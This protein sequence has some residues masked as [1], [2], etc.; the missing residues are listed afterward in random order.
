L[1]WLVGDAFYG[2]TRGQHKT[3]F[4]PCLIDAVEAGEVGLL[5]PWAK[6][7]WRKLNTWPFAWGL[8]FSVNC[9]DDA[10]GYTAASLAA[11]SEAYPLLEGYVR[12][13]REIEICEAWGLPPAPPLLEQPLESDIPTLVLA[14]SYDPITPPA[15]SR[16]TAEHLGN[17]TYV[18]FP[19]EGHDVLTDNPCA[20]GI[21]N[22][23]LR[24]PSRQLDASCATAAPRFVMPGEVL[25][26][27]NFYEYYMGDIGRSQSEHNAYLAL[28]NALPPAIV[29]ALVVVVL[30]LVLRR[31]RK[32]WFDGLVF[33]GLLLA[34]TVSSLLYGISLQMRAVSQRVAG[35][36]LL[37]FGVPADT[38]VWFIVML[39]AA[40]LTT[41]LV[42][43]SIY[44]W[45]RGR[46]PVLARAALTVVML[47]AVGF[48]VLLGMW[49]WLGVLF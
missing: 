7:E 43:L 40:A 48:A 24:D 17:A 14:G 2:P 36:A 18:E 11:Q 31:W 5:Y 3:A 1:S 29:V 28:E 15:W 6:E 12:Q 46:G 35:S 32:V 25:L 9:Q 30:W 45:M 10:R 33:G 41:G 44:V 8:F 38:T 13:G 39:V 37:R 19:A 22:S 23:F 4:V 34:A 49:G 42:A 21:M 20:D 16:E 47:P 27:P 26:V